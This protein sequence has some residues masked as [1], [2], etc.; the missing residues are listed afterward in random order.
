MKVGYMYCFVKLLFQLYV[1]ICLCALLLGYNV[2]SVTY[3]EFWLKQQQ[4]NNNWGIT[5]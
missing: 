4:Q 3:C 5:N 2:K 1:H